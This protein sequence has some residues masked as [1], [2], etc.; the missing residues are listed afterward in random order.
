MVA[1]AHSARL[2]PLLLA[3]VAVL[4]VAGAQAA[5]KTTA[6]APAASSG[7]LRLVIERAYTLGHGRVALLHQRVRLRGIVKP[8]VAGQVLSVTVNAGRHRFL[9]TRR[10]VRRV[11]GHGEFTVPF[12]AT[13]L[14]T[15]YAHAKHVS[16]AAQA[17]MSASAQG[18]SVFTPAAGR[19]SSG[20]R[21]RFLQQR[22]AAVH[23]L[24]PRSGHYDDATARA[25]LAYRSSNGMSRS[26][27]AN[28]AIFARLARLGGGF[29]VRYLKHGRHVEA[30][31]ARQVLALINTD[32]SVY[33]VVHMSSGKPSTPTVLGSFKVYSKTP[34]TNSHGMVDSTYFRG[35]YAIHGFADVPTF[36]ASHG[37]LRIPVPNA[38]F[39]YTWVQYG[40]TV[41]V[42]R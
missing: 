29:H 3:A 26:F 34:G 30:N 17:A 9:S 5:T 22:L 11:G 4:P 36:A 25:V 38:A 37:C 42:Y 6:Q 32:G 12:R 19:G 7:H 27:S 2:V 35:G 41:D 15:L 31:V 23:F 24:T 16:T 18:V 21:V 10:T 39:V 40:E 28:P 33:K 14:G 20:L 8:Y 13:R 1:R